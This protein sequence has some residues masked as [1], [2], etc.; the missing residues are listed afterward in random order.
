MH[1]IDEYFDEK[2]Q[3]LV[4]KIAK[5]LKKEKLKNIRVIVAPTFVSLAKVASKAPT[6]EHSTKL[7]IP[8]K[9]N[10]V[11][12]INITNGIIPAVK[13]FSFSLSGIS[14]SFLLNTGPNSG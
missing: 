12:D 3:S 11:M 10:P 13:S 1:L 7:A 14:L 8:I 4:K 2:Q 9:N 5:A 6:A